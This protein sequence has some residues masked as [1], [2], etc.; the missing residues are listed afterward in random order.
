[1]LISFAVRRW[2]LVKPN[3]A[4]EAEERLHNIT[5]NMRDLICETDVRGIIQ[6][7]SPSY[8][9]VLGCKP[10]ALLGMSIYLGIHPDDRDE[11]VQSIH[12]A[13][14]SDSPFRAE[15][16]YCHADNTFSWLESA[17]TFRLQP[18]GK[19]TGMIWASHDISERK[20]AESAEREQ[21]LLAQAL[22]ETAA[23]LNSTLDLDEVLERILTQ[24]TRVVPN[25][26]AAR[27]NL[28]ESNA[29]RTVRYGDSPDDCQAKESTDFSENTIG[30]L[31]ILS[32]GRPL[33]IPDTLE[34]PSWTANPTNS[35]TRPNIGAPI[36]SYLG[37][38]IRVDEQ[39]VGLLA[40]F[41]P[42]PGAFLPG[43]T[44]R[45]QA[46]ADQAGIA[47]RNARLFAATR[48]HAAELERRV[49]ERTAE[50]E[51][52]RARL[53][54]ILDGIT[55]GVIYDENRGTC[56]INSGL[57]QLTGYGP[58]A[59]VGFLDLM[60]ADSMSAE[61]FAAQCKTIYNTVHQHGIWQGEMRLKGKD[62]REFDASLISTRV[63][64]PNGEVT[65]IVTVIRDIS[66][67]KALKEQQA[68]FVTNASH[69]L[70]TPIAN[71][72]TRLYLLRH[73]PEKADSHL[74]ILE[75][76]ADRIKRLIEDMLD[77]SRLEHGVIPLKRQHIVL[78]DLVDVTMRVQLPEAEQ[79]QITL[80]C[81]TPEAPVRA[82]ADP[83]RI[84]Q[85]LTNLITNALSY[86]PRG[87]QTTLRLDMTQ[88]AET[89]KE[90][91]L[92][93]VEDTGIGIA[94]EHL[95][96][97]F[98]PFYRVSGNVE[99]SGLGLAIAK[100]I[101]ELHGG[102]ITIE[103]KLGAGTRFRVRLPLT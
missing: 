68:R 37:T 16:R 22:C 58:D 35:P 45:L 91:A 69:E 36:R 100:E 39:I 10:D 43:Y 55:E 27:I 89:A 30:S 85:V 63:A 21:R 59:W 6:Y 18:D 62:N 78:Q 66:Q 74:E 103:S 76:A 57:A 33:A 38:P 9:I 75:W 5:E 81:E 92:I 94:P 47:I 20:R 11:V 19:K 61:D 29:V 32:T 23:A 2:S 3:R 102:D 17:I 48:Q 51:Q 83:D 64:R 70:R 71:I 65:G 96:R 44:E 13:L 87:G 12:K 26:T 14:L 90:Y 15:Y 7:A 25:A 42:K 97:V 72:K 67:E 24:V 52:E 40:V 79:R 56:Y 60:K 77:K 8:E 49:A 93:E 50:L 101:V 80:A 46:F 1:V 84:I 88:D 54:A 86:T 53:S 99:G 31:R 28:T 4:T 34:S 82:L 98:E 95:V 41:S 73:Q